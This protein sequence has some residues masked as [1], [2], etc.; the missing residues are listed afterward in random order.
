MGGRKILNERSEMKVVAVYTLTN[1]GGLA[2][3][4]ANSEGVLVGYNEDKPNWVAV[5][6]DEDGR[7]RFDWCGCKIYLDE[8]VRV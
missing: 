2:I 7:G 8:C 4:D 5:D 1:C 6:Y 3:Y